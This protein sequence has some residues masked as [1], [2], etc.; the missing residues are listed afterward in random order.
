M[1]AAAYGSPKVWLRAP[2]N[3]AYGTGFRIP[4]GLSPATLPASAVKAR[5]AKILGLL[6]FDHSGERDAAARAV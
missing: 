6:G 4:F 2:G 5:F 1:K 3:P